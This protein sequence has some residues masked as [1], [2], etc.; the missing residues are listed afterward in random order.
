MS[1]NGRCL[2]SFALCDAGG[3]PVG[4]TPETW[5]PRAQGW[6]DARPLVALAAA[7][8]GLALVVLR[9][10]SAVKRDA[11][12]HLRYA[13]EIAPPLPPI[14]LGAAERSDFVDE[15]LRQTWARAG[16]PRAQLAWAEGELERRGTPAL[17]T[18]EQVRS[19]NLSS[20]WRIPHTSGTAWLK[21]V[22]PFFAHEGAVIERLQAFA[23]PRLIA[24][25]GELCLLDEI[26]GDELYAAPLDTALRMVDLLVDIQHTTTV[27]ASF[28]AILPDWRLAALREGAG[29]ALEQSAAALS[30]AERSAIGRLIDGLDGRAQQL[31]ACGIP[32][33]LVHGDFHPGNVRGTPARMTLLDWGDSGLGHPLLDVAAFTERM[34]AVDTER[35]VAHWL[36]LWRDA[37]A[38]SDPARALVV[39][40]PIGAL[41]QAMIYQG[42]ID[43]IEPNERIYHA[44]DPLA[45]LRRAAGAGPV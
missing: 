2:V 1:A 8:W 23:V 38:G 21:A 44:N 39:V 15:P 33:G 25:R 7:E 42:F 34:P 3:A 6:S 27:D 29:H 35:V 13:A 28:Q 10:M 26:A 14:E 12:W 30:R 24:R 31:E 32:D 36:Q 19:W 5:M 43:R 45:W 41:R 37:V 20:L 40:E 16:G 17:G 22:P 4:S 11:V 9:L 18:S